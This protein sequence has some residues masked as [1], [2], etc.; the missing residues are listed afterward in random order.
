[1]HEQGLLLLWTLQDLASI[2]DVTAAIVQVFI[3]GDAIFVVAGLHVQG[4][5][6]VQQLSHRVCHRQWAQTYR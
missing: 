1:M 5:F 6:F 4:L 2:M 3:V